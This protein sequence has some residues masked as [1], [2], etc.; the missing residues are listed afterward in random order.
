MKFLTY[1]RYILCF[2]LWKKAVHLSSLAGTDKRK[3]IDQMRLEVRNLT[4][5]NDFMSQHVKYNWPSWPKLTMTPN[6]TS[7]TIARDLKNVT[8]VLFGANVSLR[9]CYK[10]NFVQLLF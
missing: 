5:P 3:E 1:L 7:S 6:G 2:K 10:V 4:A 9:D 8:L